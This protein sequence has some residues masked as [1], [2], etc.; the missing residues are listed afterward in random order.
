MDWIKRNDDGV[1]SLVRQKN[2]EWEQ[3]DGDQR[4][5]EQG[6]GKNER[7]IRENVHQE[8]RKI[9]IKG[10]CYPYLGSLS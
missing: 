2:W 5:K 9:N 4:D 6:G 7:K 3:G 1:L 8:N 10:F